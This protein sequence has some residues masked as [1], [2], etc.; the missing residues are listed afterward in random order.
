MIIMSDLSKSM[1]LSPLVFIAL[2]SGSLC[3]PVPSPG[4][5][6][7]SDLRVMSFNIRYGTANDGDN[8]WE[9]RKDFL[10]ETIAAVNPD[11]LGTQETLGFQRDYLARRLQDYEVLGA[12]R[13]DGRE[14]GEMAALYYR[15][16]RF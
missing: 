14:K 13:D 12:G 4:N 5:E 2:L 10:I 11:L 6:G 9:H 7:A 15:R 8:D 1:F 16:S 3:R